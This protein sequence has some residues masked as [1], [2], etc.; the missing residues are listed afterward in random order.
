MHSPV[1]A[2][3][4]NSVRDRSQMLCLP[5]VQRW[6]VTRAPF[7]RVAFRPVARCRVPTSPSAIFPIGD[8][9]NILLTLKI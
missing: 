6:S 2:F 3:Y 8:L 1:I 4:E 5:P 9:I 7:C